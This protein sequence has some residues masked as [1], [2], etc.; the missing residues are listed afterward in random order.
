VL[1]V[2]A[3][4]Q[5]PFL[6]YAVAPTGDFSSPV[7][8]VVAQD[9]SAPAPSEPSC[10]GECFAAEDCDS[11]IDDDCNDLADGCDPACNGCAD[12]EL[13][14]NDIPFSVPLLGDGTHS[15]DICRT[16]DSEQIDYTTTAAN[17]YY[18]RVY[19]FRADASG[20]TA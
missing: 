8:V 18:L 19:S 17:T 5:T 10:S 14:P 4:E 2:N 20:G 9:A 11:E 6:V 13:E 1:E 16:G 12:D 3:P 15:L 7:Q